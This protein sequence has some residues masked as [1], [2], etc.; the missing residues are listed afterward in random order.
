MHRPRR[1]PR[2]RT[3]LRP[4]PDRVHRVGD[5]RNVGRVRLRPEIDDSLARKAGDCGAADVLDIEIRSS[6]LDDGDDARSDVEDA[7][8]P[9]PDGG[10]T[11]LVRTDRTRRRV[12]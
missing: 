3:G 10:T 5:G 2:I 6:R 9:G 7:W 4:E 11:P 1:R 8:I 12:R